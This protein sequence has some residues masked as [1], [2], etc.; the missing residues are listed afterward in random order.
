[1]K[2]IGDIVRELREARG[3]GVVDLATA[4]GITP[5]YVSLIEHNHRRSVPLSTLAKLAAALGVP[6]TELLPPELA[7]PS[8]QE[9]ELE[10]DS[11]WRAFLRTARDLTPEEREEILAYMRFKRSQRKQRK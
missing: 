6:T 5:G 2:Q 9:P 7:E 4:A 3:M 1:M 8:V 11:E 10:D